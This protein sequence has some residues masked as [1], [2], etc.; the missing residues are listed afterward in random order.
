[1]STFPEPGEPVR[2]S[3]GGAGFIRWN[4]RG[5]EIFFDDTS[6]DWQGGGWEGGALWSAPV[7][8]SVPHGR[9]AYGSPTRLFSGKDVPTSL[10]FFSTRNWDVDPD[11]QRVFVVSRGRYVNQRPVALENFP[12]W[13]R[14]R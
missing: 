4:P 9:D 1:M 12:R 3:V 6:G 7:D 10:S 11:G 14:E 2:V 5:D 8:R 13:Y